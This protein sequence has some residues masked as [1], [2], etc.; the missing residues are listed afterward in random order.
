ML[1]IFAHHSSSLPLHGSF[2][3]FLIYYN[4]IA[5]VLKI[6]W[7]ARNFLQLIF[8]TH[9]SLMPCRYNETLQLSKVFMGRIAA[10]R[11]HREWQALDARWRKWRGGWKCM[12][13]VKLRWFIKKIFYVYGI[14][15][16]KQCLPS[17]ST[18]KLLH[19]IFKRSIIFFYVYGW[20]LWHTMQTT[21][22]CHSENFFISHSN[23]VI[24]TGN[25]NLC[26]IFLCYE[27]C[28]P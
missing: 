19:A 1:K 23:N 2:F 21:R 9:H 13:D 28:W 27:N 22:R 6:L 16:R 25:M 18:R 12:R 26:C 20:Y 11:Y 15:T 24:F 8:I 7:R 4:F 5:F 10:L 3:Y 17:M 14:I